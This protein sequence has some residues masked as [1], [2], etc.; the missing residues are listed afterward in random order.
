LSWFGSLMT[1]VAA[2]EVTTTVEIVLPP[3]FLVLPGDEDS[4]WVVEPVG[5]LDGEST[6]SLLCFCCN[7]PTEPTY[8]L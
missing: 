7:N 1:S 4:W 3:T 8:K 6:S 2:G 5:L